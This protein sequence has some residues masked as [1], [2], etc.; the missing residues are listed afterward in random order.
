MISPCGKKFTS[1]SSKPFICPFWSVNAR[2]ENSAWEPLASVSPFST[3]S[4]ST[5]GTPGRS[6]GQ[7][8]MPGLVSRGRRGAAQEEGLCGSGRVW[9]VPQW[10]AVGTGSEGGADGIGGARGPEAFECF[11]PSL[12]L[13]TSLLRSFWRGRRAAGG[14]WPPLP[15][16]A[17]ASRPAAES[18]G[19]GAHT[20][21]AVQDGAAAS[22]PAVLSVMG[23]GPPAW[24]FLA[25]V[26]SPS[27]RASF[28]AR[29]GRRWSAG[30][31]RPVTSFINKL[32]LDYIHAH[33]FCIVYTVWNDCDRDSTGDKI[34]TICPFV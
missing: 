1:K 7:G 23:R 33:L 11:R 26:L 24:S 10:P 12:G 27:R 13:G 30:Q 16:W 22:H 29:A 31:I 2:S 9:G 14:P 21:A 34:F 6:S 15:A 19:P 17:P 3:R 25:W 18:Y 8:A 20:S 5:G 28:R 4:E 32:L